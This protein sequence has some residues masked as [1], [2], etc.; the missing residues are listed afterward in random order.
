MLSDDALDCVLT[1]KPFLA[2][3]SHFGLIKVNGEDAE[4]FLQ[5][6]LTCDMSLVKQG[7][8]K[9]GAHCNP[10]GRAQSSFVALWAHNAFYLILPVDQVEPTKVALSKFALFSKA[11]LSASDDFEIWGVGNSDIPGWEQPSADHS[12]ASPIGIWLHLHCGLQWFLSAPDTT[13]TWLDQAANKGIA[14]FTESAAADKLWQLH[15]VQQG[16]SFIPQALSEQW[17][18]QEIN[19]DLIDGV[20]FRKGCYK[21]QEIVARIHYRGQTKVRTFLL[22]ARFPEGT[23]DRQLATVSVGEKIITE[24]GAGT[25]LA[26]APSEPMALQ[27]LAVLKI[28]QSESQ[29]MTLETNPDASVRPLPLPYAIT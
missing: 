19:Y 13:G 15:L 18:P 4:T 10:K 26:V 28:E 2:R 29:N 23:D 14:T 11:T 12:T 22:E 3:L 8:P 25:V 7:H 24:N 20:S 16:V 5:G 6:Q 1:G 17:I 27:L 21:G 9:L